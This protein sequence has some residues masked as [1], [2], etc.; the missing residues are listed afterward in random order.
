[1]SNN[2]FEK[3][4]NQMH[5]TIDSSVALA[6]HNKNQEVEVIHLLWALLT[7]TNSVLNQLLNKMNVNK[8]AIEL[9]AKSNAQKLPSVSSVTKEN[10]KLSRNLLA[11][12]QKAEGQ[13]ASNGD[14]FIA[15]D[16]WLISNFDL[17][18]MKEVLGKYIDLREAKKEL[19]AMRAGKTIESNS[20]DDNL[21]A[22]N[23]YGIDLN[24]RAI[25]G[26]LDPVI[27]RDEQINRMM[28]ILIR[29]T[30]NNPIL[31]G[32]PGT[33]KT[34]IA[35]GLAQRIVNKDVPTSLLNKRVV[36]LDMSA[37]IAGAKY[38]GEF[39]D[40]LKSVI[41][42]VKKAGNIIL[43]IDEIH[44]IIG[45]GASEGSMDAANILKPSLAR[46]ELHTIGA[47]TLKEYRKYFE[48][49]A[50]MQ[51]RFQP[52]K[53]DEPTVNEALQI[54]RGIKEKLETHHNVTI[55]DSALVAAAK[56][57][58]RYIT[59]RFLPDKAIDLIDEAAAELKMQIESEPTALSTIKREIQTLNVE[60]EALKMEKNKKNEERVAQIEK[61]LANK[62]E[63]KQ[64]LEAR[65]ENEKQTFNATS[66]LKV[67]IDEL[68]TKANIAKRESK[69]E[70]AA[71]I[72]YGE[73]PAL[74]AKIKENAQKWEQMQKEGTLLRNSVDEEAIASIVS[75]WTGI[76]VNKMM[77]SEKQKVLK[78]EEVLKQ[79]VI[80]QDEAIKAISRAIK[81]NKAGLSETSRPIGSFLFLGPTGVG[82]TESA[83]TLAKFLFDDAKSLIRFDMSEY[84]E[85]HAVSRLVGAAP[86]YVGYEEGGQL[87]EAVRRKPYSVILF[88]EV[89]KA[90]PDVFNIL[91]QVL[92]DGRLTDNKGVTVD[93]KNTIIILTSNIGSARII[94][95]R[96]KEERRKAVL[97][98]LKMHFRP[99]F[100]N[101]L[102]DIVIFEQL[103]LSA[104]TNIVDILF[105]NIKKK[106]EE[107]DIK[108]SLTQNAKEYIAKIG[109]DPVYG[110]RP[111][112][113][114][115]Y[116]IVEDKL[117]DLILEDKIGEGSSIEFDVQNDEV[118][119]NIA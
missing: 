49:D 88:D 37:L 99:E 108:I 75:R 1:M 115:I 33:G 87:T 36:S 20:A 14:K 18:I 89:E 52:V 7:N 24:K 109:F 4:T 53:V 25:D 6:L 39:E 8:A 74:E 71:K 31:L 93:F 85:K 48:K 50:A 68:K 79:D 82:K 96:D 104:I 38:R 61:E 105:N 62:N 63:E 59:D 100:L 72:E 110:A 11:S 106:V 3:M 101:R 70:E 45:A 13:M 26:E 91:L 117:A 76:P 116:E 55:N 46:G 65:F 98:E 34:A 95:I 56:L 47:T 2:I 107:K 23:K 54:L 84:M 21:E 112:K 58:N 83:K 40:R 92:D 22:L 60:K 66:E 94:E 67:K 42:E 16:T 118:V 102:D 73:I 9:E 81:R 12:L 30:K 35:E 77:D 114:A 64:N 111:L 103:N 97:D 57:S 28:Q 19:E 29:K 17:P 44:T 86:G 113:R 80:G 32:E 90:H 43:F 69:F 27:G 51:R 41:D 5:E 10:I 15:I 78:V 119:V